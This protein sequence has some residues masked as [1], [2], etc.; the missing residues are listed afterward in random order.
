MVLPLAGG[1]GDVHVPLV[2][3]E[4]AHEGDGAVGRH[5]A[6]QH[7]KLRASR[8][9]QGSGALG[10]DEQPLLDE[11]L[12]VVRQQRT[13]ADKLHPAVDAE[14][15][16]PRRGAM[17]VDFGGHGCASGGKRTINNREFQ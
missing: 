15:Q 10:V 4:K 1:H 3:G 9:H 6:G 16:L 14:L 11:V 7:V 2:P 5:R 12:G 13:L 17:A 8:T